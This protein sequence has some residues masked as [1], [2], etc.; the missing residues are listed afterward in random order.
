V[1]EQRHE[2]VTGETVPAIEPGTV[3]DRESVVG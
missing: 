1:I 2:E 3:H